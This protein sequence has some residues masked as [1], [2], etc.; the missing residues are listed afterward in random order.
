[1]RAGANFHA[2][3]I[4][5]SDCVVPSLGVQTGPRTAPVSAQPSLVR[6]LHF[7]IAHTG[8][9]RGRQAGSHTRVDTSGRSVTDGGR[10]VFRWNQ[11]V[12]GSRIPSRCTAFDGTGELFSILC[13]D[14]RQI[15]GECAGKHPRQNWQPTA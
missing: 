13:R 15:S 2:V 14:S 7:L 8:V 3:L 9:A 11:E 12:C 1:W 6:V 5:M 4:L 10:A